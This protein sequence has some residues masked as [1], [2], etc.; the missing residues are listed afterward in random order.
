[1]A[2]AKIYN[3]FGLKP[4]LDNDCVVGL[5]PNS[6]DKILAKQKIQPKIRLD[7]VIISLDINQNSR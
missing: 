5:K 1:M 6:I 3:K 2:L 7:F 4:K